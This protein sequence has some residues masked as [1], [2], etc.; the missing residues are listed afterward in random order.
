M[1]KMYYEKEK[2]KRKDETVKPASSLDL[3]Y[4]PN[5]EQFFN[6][7]IR[8]GQSF[9]STRQAKGNKDP[10]TSGEHLLYVDGK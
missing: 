7:G 2:T 6:S 9:I 5:M 4:D 3:L 1:L 10:K 8:G